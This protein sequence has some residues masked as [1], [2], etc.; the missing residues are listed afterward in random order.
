[1]KRKIFVGVFFFHLKDEKRARGERFEKQ[2]TEI[3][4]RLGTMCSFSFRIDLL[5][6]KMLQNVG[7]G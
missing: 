6:R 3:N 7:F 2:N 5:G 4:F 1:M